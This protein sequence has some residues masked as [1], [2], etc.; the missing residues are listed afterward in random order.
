MYNYY[1]YYYYH[2]FLSSVSGYIDNRST[3]SR[4]GKGW[5]NI[6]NDTRKNPVSMNYVQGRWLQKRI[7]PTRV[8]PRK[9]I[10]THRETSVSSFS[11]KII[12]IN[13][14]NIR[15]GFRRGKSIHPFIR[16]IMNKSGIWKII[17]N[18]DNGWVALEREWYRWSS[19]S[20]FCIQSWATP[21][22]GPPPPQPVPRPACLA[23]DNEDDED[24]EVD[25]EP[26]G[27]Y[28]GQPGQDWRAGKEQTCGHLD[29]LTLFDSWL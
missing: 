14:F 21:P 28:G 12:R 27:E 19:P 20:W 1:E 13:F 5:W 2:S 18:D 8:Y 11:W 26:G 10:I 29:S 4:Q 15:A 16:F 3:R 17:R 25:G 7:V 9:Y 22:P 6:W 23:F 24:G